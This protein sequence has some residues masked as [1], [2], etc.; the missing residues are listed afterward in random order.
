MKIS[1][2]RCMGADPL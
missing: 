1:K 2:V